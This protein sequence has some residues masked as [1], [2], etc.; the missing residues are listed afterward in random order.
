MGVLAFVHLRFRS[1]MKNATYVFQAYSGLV[2]SSVFP[3]ECVERCIVGF[4]GRH[5]FKLVAGTAFY[6]WNAKSY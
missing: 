5:V 1:I 6:N 4:L 2:L 3:T